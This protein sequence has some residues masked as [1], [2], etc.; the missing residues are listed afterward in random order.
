MQIE[1]S[2]EH[3]KKTGFSKCESLE[4]DSN[5]TVES[6][7]QSLKHCEPRVLTDEGIQIDTKDEHPENAE[8]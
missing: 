4:P 3:S 6:F 2:P 1:E 8:L 7:P 5:V